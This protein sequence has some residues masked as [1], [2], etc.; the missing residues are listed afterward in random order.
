MDGVTMGVTMVTMGHTLYGFPKIQAL[1]YHNSCL[2]GLMA[3]SIYE[4]REQLRRKRMS[5]VNFFQTL[6]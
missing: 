3:L 2:G 4:S 5:L 6:Q 1:T